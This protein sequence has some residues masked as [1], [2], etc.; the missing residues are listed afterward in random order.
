MD[1]AVPPRPGSRERQAAAGFWRAHSSL[2]LVAALTAV[3]LGYYVA[4][5]VGLTLRYSPDGPLVPLAPQRDPDRAPLLARSPGLA[6]LLAAFPG[7]LLASRGAA[8]RAW[9]A[10]FATNCSEALL[11]LLLRRYTDLPVRFDTLRRTA[12]FIGGAVPAPFSP[13]SPT[14]G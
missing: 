7:H 1:A 6:L 3:F 4:A 11:A 5:R 2:R 13:R 12:V 14:R 9:L 8:A 10:L